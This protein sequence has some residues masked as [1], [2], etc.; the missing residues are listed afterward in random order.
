MNK[1]VDTREGSLSLLHSQKGIYRERDSLSEIEVL[2]SPK[3]ICSPFNLQKV[4]LLK[5]QYP[6]LKVRNIVPDSEVR[7]AFLFFKQ[8]Q[9]LKRTFQIK[10]W[11]LLVAVQMELEIIIFCPLP[12]LVESNLLSLLCVSFQF[13]AFGFAK[14]MLLL[15]FFKLLFLFLM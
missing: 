5:S 3:D 13:K 14:S 6:S 7:K 10:S 11:Q 2:F 4:P 12:K 9:N 8:K 1:L 15:L